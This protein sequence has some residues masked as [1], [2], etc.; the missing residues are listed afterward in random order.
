MMGKPDARKN[1]TIYAMIQFWKY[2]TTTTTT[3]VTDGSS[4][5]NSNS[6]RTQTVFQDFMEEG[7]QQQQQQLR[8]K[9]DNGN[10][11]PL[12]IAM[13]WN[14]F[15]PEYFSRISTQTH[16][17]TT[18]DTA[19]TTTTLLQT[20]LQHYNIAL[21]TCL[22]EPYAR[23]KSSFFYEGDNHGGNTNPKFLRDPLGTYGHKDLRFKKKWGANDTYRVNVNKPNYYTAFL[24]GY[25]QNDQEDEDDTTTT[26]SN[27]GNYSRHTRRNNYDYNY[28][29]CC[30]GS[31]SN[32]TNSTYGLNRT[33]LEIAKQR[34]DMFDTILILEDPATHHQLL[35]YKPTTTKQSTTDT[36]MTI[37]SS[38]KSG[39]NRGRGNPKY[40]KRMQA[41]KEQFQ[42]SRAEFYHDNQ[43]DYELYQYAI[44]LASAAKQT[45]NTPPTPPTQHQH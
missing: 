22:R 25:G 45:T 29:A 18:D 36:D 26:A 6:S 3:M 43:L 34:L 39:G 5:D 16:P 38:K 28:F 17:K 10:M 30:G 14:Y 4:S 20:L 1:Q 21:L 44:T 2:N 42:L 23:F 41:A 32:T 33:H 24:N 13:E 12:F 19:T 8:S 11:L 35:P 31:D 37:L 9:A 40:L 15:E 27:I 7:Y